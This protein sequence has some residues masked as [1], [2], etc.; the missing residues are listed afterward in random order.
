MTD[1]YAM[2][3][4]YTRDGMTAAV[5]PDVQLSWIS[6]IIEQGMSWVIGRAI[7]RM[8]IERRKRDDSKIEIAVV[9]DLTSE[10]SPKKPLLESGVSAMGKL[11]E[12][13]F[14]PDTMEAFELPPGEGSV[15]KYE[16]P[17]LEHPLALICYGIADTATSSFLQ[18]AE[19][20]RF[21]MS[22]ERFEFSFDIGMKP[23][24]LHAWLAKTPDY[25]ETTIVGDLPWRSNARTKK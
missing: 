25:D 9:S 10:E 11:Y 23:A 5:H 7:W 13:G 12:K 1:P 15:I 18:G 3:A 8:R 20:C 4:V 17:K 19:K 22:R 2:E 6:Y 24:E 16:E 21:Q 14:F